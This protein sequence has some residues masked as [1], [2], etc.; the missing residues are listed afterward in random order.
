MKKMLN[1]V[2]GFICLQGLYSCDS[3]D[4]VA[5]ASTTKRECF[6]QEEKISC[7]KF[8][9]IMGNN[10]TPN[11]KESV[12]LGSESITVA[13]FHGQNIT[14]LNDLYLEDQKTTETSEYNCSFLVKRNSTMTLN[15][16]NDKLM[17][18]FYNPQ[19]H[20]EYLDLEFVK[21]SE[22][23]FIFNDLYQNDGEQIKTEIMLEFD[24]K[25]STVRFSSR[26]QFE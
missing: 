19:D 5:S 4:Q 18:R 21:R 9:Q 23:Q 26:C 14:L 1:I 11:A 8:D 10:Q 7:E 16:T 3:S 22:N 13:R 15:A 12:T 17:A 2:I 20:S 24:L 6:Y 25:E